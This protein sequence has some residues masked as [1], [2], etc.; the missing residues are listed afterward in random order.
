MTLRRVR[1]LLSDEQL[2]AISGA[3]PAATGRF[4]TW[5]VIFGSHP[6]TVDH[7]TNRAVSLVSLNGG[8]SWLCGLA[9]RLCRM[10]HPEEA[11]AALAELRTY[12]AFLEANFRVRPIP[13]TDES[14]PDFEV[15]AGDGSV[16]VEVFAK[17]QDDTEAEQW[18]QAQAG[19]TPTEV[20]SHTHKTKGAEIVVT[21]S[22]CH[23][24]GSP[25]PRKAHDSVQANVIQR[26]CGAKGGEKQ[27]PANKPS[28]LW[29]DMQSFGA[30]PDAV[31]IEQATPLVSGH[32]G[33]TS[34]ALWYA[35]YGWKGA[36]I[37][38]ED[39][40]QRE[41]VVPMGHDG[42]FRLS[43]ERKSKLSAAVL[44]LPQATILLE[45]PWAEHSLPARFRLF[46]ERLPFFNLGRSICNWSPGD[47]EVIANAGRRQIDA[48]K[49]MRNELRS[50]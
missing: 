1:D 30:W 36:P 2:V 35:F 34:G 25:D 7:L 24:G 37:F 23:P 13:V 9:A 32:H 4:P 22:E 17:H 20:E 38:E 47:A 3:P 41:R 16:I 14:T 19:N 33:L 6:G 28:I 18:R 15:D 48:V 26:I 49:N 50:S 45:N 11:S 8:D 39:Y 27:F 40:L 44:A 10:D 43:G 42:R 29:I 5:Y 12:G 31:D 21:I 46:A